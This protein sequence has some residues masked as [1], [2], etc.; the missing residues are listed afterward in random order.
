LFVHLLQVK[1]KESR[2]LKQLYS[3]LD[4][5]LHNFRKIFSNV[6]IDI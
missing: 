2:L 6:A 3:F 4:S 5:I 1:K